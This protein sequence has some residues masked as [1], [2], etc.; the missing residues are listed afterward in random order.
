MAIQLMMPSRPPSLG[1]VPGLVWL[2]L[3]VNLVSV[4]TLEGL[5][6]RT[7]YLPASATAMSLAGGG[8]ALPSDIALTTV[9][10]AH[11]WGAARETVEYG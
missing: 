4:P 2:F 9:N 6:W 3:L 1:A 5:G 7:S 11:I 8:I 10:P